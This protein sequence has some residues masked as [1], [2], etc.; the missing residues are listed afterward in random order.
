M[1]GIEAM[2]KVPANWMFENRG[3]DE[4]CLKLVQSPNTIPFDKHP[5]RLNLRTLFSGTRR[6]SPP[7]STLD[8]IIYVAD[9]V[10]NCF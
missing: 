5:F 8:L 6:V 10:E 9:L 1:Y 4:S 2:L 7:K 3:L